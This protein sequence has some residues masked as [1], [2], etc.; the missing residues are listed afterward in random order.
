[1]YEPT[2]VHL[3]YPHQ[4]TIFMSASWQVCVQTLTHS[5]VRM[6][7]KNFILAMHIIIRWFPTSQ[8]QIDKITNKKDIL[9]SHISSLYAKL[10]LRVTEMMRL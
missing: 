6:L 8:T 4:S 9:F 5:Y 1:M 7:G 3:Q 2:T 10:N